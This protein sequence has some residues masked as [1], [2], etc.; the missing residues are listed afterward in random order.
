MQTCQEKQIALYQ[1]QNGELNYI[2]VTL[3]Q[4]RPGAA[5]AETW[6]ETSKCYG[7]R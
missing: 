1:T 4:N 3:F 2:D 6:V 7:T 5:C